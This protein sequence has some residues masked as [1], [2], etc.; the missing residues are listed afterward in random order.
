MNFINRKPLPRRVFL[1]GAGGVVLALPFL[2]ASIS[3]AQNVPVPKRFVV[4]FTPCGAGTGSYPRSLDLSGTPYEPLQPYADQ[5]I[6]TR[7]IAMKS[8]A[9]QSTPPHP[10][11]FGHMLTGDRCTISGDDILG[12]QNESIDQF[13]ARRMGPTRVA[14]SLHGV[15]NERNMSWARAPSGAVS[16]LR[17]EQNPGVAFERL[18][19]DVAAGSDAE[20]SD[21]TDDRPR[22][23]R[24]AIVDAVR[25]SYQALACKL[26]GEDRKRLDAHLD[27]VRDMERNLVGGGAAVTRECTVPG[28]PRSFD[29]RS[30]P[31]GRDIGRAHM[32]VLVRALECDITRVG[33][34]QWYS[35]TAVHGSPYGWATGL[36]SHHVSSHEGGTAGHDRAYAGE[37]ARFLGLLQEARA[38]DGSPLLHH[39]VVL[40]ISELGISG[41]VHHLA[42]L[43]VIIAGSAGGKL[44][45]GQY[46]DL[47]GSNRNGFTRAADWKAQQS[48][49][50]YFRPFDVS[51]NDLFVELANAVAPEGA[52]PVKTFGRADVCTGGVP[53]LRA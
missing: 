47:L 40:C 42:D 15:V 14:S 51:H 3:K 29:V 13:I 36:K 45:T 7:G 53:Q 25:G 37:L 27:Y 48:P 52:E 33:T 23:R 2:E 24:Q 44:K 4:W 1:K 38:E 18:F 16:S 12:A 41:T 6:V 19:R 11:G 49:G 28:A 21:T 17:A 5:L 35:H 43:P 50:E 30:I 26:G 8:I 34:L 32:D 46:I 10:T 31:S 20:S 39:T 9:G 22:L